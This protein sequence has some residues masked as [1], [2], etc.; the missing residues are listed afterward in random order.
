M[1]IESIEPHAVLVPLA[2]PTAFSTRSIK[3]REYV[4]VRIVDESGASGIGYTYAGDS[5]PLAANRH[6]ATART[7]AARPKRLRNRRELGTDLPGFAAPWP[8][9]R[10]P[11]N[12]QRGRHRPL[13]PPRQ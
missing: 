2:T 4:I 3:G 1:R 5:G 7:T 11:A 6:R 8:P 10:A 13:G 12:A 9:R